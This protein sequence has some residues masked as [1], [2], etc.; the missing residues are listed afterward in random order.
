MEDA[1]TKE[2]L[3][4]PV[5]PLRWLIANKLTGERK[6]VAIDLFGNEF[7]A[8]IDLGDQSEDELAEIKASYQATYEHLIRSALSA[9]PQPAASDVPHDVVRALEC[10]ADG[11]RYTSSYQCMLTAREALKTLD[12]PAPST[13]TEEALRADLER[14]MAIGNE[15]LNEAEALRAEN[16]RLRA[17]LEDYV[18]RD[19]E[20]QLAHPDVKPSA[21]HIRMMEAGELALS[22]SR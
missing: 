19:A 5:K 6:L 17:A 9:A 15:H 7:G 18:Q 8:R 4:C 13:S 20:I 10:I 1:K 11:K 12:T 21:R 14:Q 22:T 16:A 2:L 3:P